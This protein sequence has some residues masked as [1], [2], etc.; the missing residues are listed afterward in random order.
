MKYPKVVKEWYDEVIG[1][2]NEMNRAIART[3]N[4]IG[5]G[6]VTCLVCDM[7]TPSRGIYIPLDHREDLGDGEHFEN[8]IRIFSFALC[9]ECNVLANDDDREVVRDHLKKAVAESAKSNPET[10]Q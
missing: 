7:P 8:M 2:E 1:I 6:L 4:M 9:D 5:T 3:I 10:I